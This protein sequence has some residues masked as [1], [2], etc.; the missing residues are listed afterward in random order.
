MKRKPNLYKEMEAEAIRRVKE[1]YKYRDADI[2]YINVPNI[3]GEI[4]TFNS[5]SVEKPMWYLDEYDVSL[6]QLR[7]RCFFERKYNII[8]DISG[9]GQCNQV[10]SLVLE[11]WKEFRDKYS[12]QQPAPYHIEIK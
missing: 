1:L 6:L 10:V 2:F 7:V 9:K 3:L 11:V 4:I 12:E 8:L 5:Y